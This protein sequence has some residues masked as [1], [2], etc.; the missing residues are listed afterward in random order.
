MRPRTCNDV[1]LE[2][3]TDLVESQG[4]YGK[5]IGLGVSYI[6]AGEESQIQILK[7]LEIVVLKK[8]LTVVQ[9]EYC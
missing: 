4:K 3:N 6:P 2:D 9:R 5:N 8:N 1:S 7:I